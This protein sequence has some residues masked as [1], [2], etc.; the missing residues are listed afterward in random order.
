MRV[1]GTRISLFLLVAAACGGDDGSAAYNEAAPLFDPARVV[2]V[3]VEMAPADWDA[4]R[5]QTRTAQDLFDRPDCVGSP[6]P[7]PF[8]YFPASVTIDGVLVENVS[9]RKKGFIGSLSDVKPSLKIGFDELDP[10]LL[11]RGLEK[12]TLN[13]A[14]QDASYVNQCIAYQ[15]FERA[16]I[17]APRCNF[18]TVA[19]NG[20]P[21]GVYV[22]VESIETELL[23]H[24][25]GDDDGNL[26]EGTL[27]DF[28]DDWYGTLEKKNNQAAADWSDVDALFA[29]AQA[30]DEEL[31]AQLDA[32]IDLEEFFTFW[33]TESLI[34]HWD[35]YAG[36]INNYW[37][38]QDGGRLRFLPW[39]VDQVL[40]VRNPVQGDAGPSSVYAT[41]VLAWRVYRHNEGRARYYA[42]MRRVLETAW[43]EAALAAE[44]DRMAA[45][46]A[47]HLGGQD[48][49]GELRDRHW[50]VSSRRDQV[51]AELD[52]DPPAWAYDLRAP[53]CE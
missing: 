12:M 28:T 8:T 9:I 29:A 44:I 7:N 15:V 42:A 35:G 45:L 41:G 52:G 26:Y 18:A 33:A 40:A 3:E 21:L 20:Q 49:S 16:G 27:S 4:L 53:F 5:T 38:Y 48:L 14:V 10:D 47:P 32:V 43:D 17:P 39:G 34:Q 50:F 37:L 22:H 13:N 51:L 24:H 1:A 2:A 6:W 19:V 36:N 11:H 23:A 30:P 31:L 25:F 46:L